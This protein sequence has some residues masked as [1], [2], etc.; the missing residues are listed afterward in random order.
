MKR[1]WER[2]PWWPGATIWY[3]PPLEAVF[4]EDCRRAGLDL[5]VI[6]PVVGN[7]LRWVWKRSVLDRNDDPGWQRALIAARKRQTRIGPAPSGYS[8]QPPPVAPPDDLTVK[9]VIRRATGYELALQTTPVDRDRSSKAKARRRR[10]RERQ[11]PVTF[12]TAAFL[13]LHW[14][15]V[16]GPLASQ[17]RLDAAD[18]DGPIGLRLAVAYRDVLDEREK[19][20][21]AYGRAAKRWLEL[22][23]ELR[24]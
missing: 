11:A 8:Y 3:S 23:R 20:D 6:A 19:S 4:V 16:F 2:A 10:S 17:F 13:S 15:D 5:A 1:I 9:R 12:D 18:I 14:R 21:G 22:M 24:P 7:T